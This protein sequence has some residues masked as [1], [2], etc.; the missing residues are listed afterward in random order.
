MKYRTIKSEILNFDKEVKSKMYKVR[1]LNYYERLKLIDELSKVWSNIYLDLY[2]YREKQP[3]DNGKDK[4]YNKL[5]LI[6]DEIMYINI[7]R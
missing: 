4:L 7:R 2:D 3:L 5:N 1:K 6:R